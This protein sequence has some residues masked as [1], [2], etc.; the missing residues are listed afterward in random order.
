MEASELV[1]VLTPV[2][3]CEQ[4]AK[5]A[6]CAGGNLIAAIDTSRLSIVDKNATMKDGAKRCLLLCY[7]RSLCCSGAVP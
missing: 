3:L 6:H 4:L 7:C 2:T 1:T 5:G